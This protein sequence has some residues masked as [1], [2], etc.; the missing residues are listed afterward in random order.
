MAAKSRG[1][2]MKTKFNAKKVYINGRKFDSKAE[3]ERAKI[4][5]TWLACGIIRELEYQPK[6]ALAPCFVDNCGRKNRP[7]VYIADFSYI[8]AETGRSIVEDVKGM[9]T[10]DYKLK[11]KLFRHEFPELVHREIINGRDPLL[12]PKKPKRRS[13]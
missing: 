7:I 2:I 4:L 8:E 10:P 12:T 5:Q 13:K 6:F 1:E 11:A 3:S 9:M